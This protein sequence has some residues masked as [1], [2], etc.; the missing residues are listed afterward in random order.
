M[1]SSC[2]QSSL[3]SEQLAVDASL[4]TFEVPAT[5]TGEHTRTPEP[6]TVTKID[7]SEL[8]LGTLV[9]IEDPKATP[10]PATPARNPAR[11]VPFGGTDPATMDISYPTTPGATIVVPPPVPRR[12]AARSTPRPGSMLITPDIFKPPPPR[13]ERR[14]IGKVGGEENEKKEGAKKEDIADEKKEAKV[15]AE[16]VEKPTTVAEGIGQAIG[17]V[18][19]TTEETKE[20]PKVK[21]GASATDLAAQESLAVPE[22]AADTTT[23]NTPTNSSSPLPECV[24]VPVTEAPPMTTATETTPLD[25][26]SILSAS[27]ASVYTKD[28][29]PSIPTTATTEDDLAEDEGWVGNA[30]WEDRAWNRLVRIC[31]EMFWVCVG[32]GIVG[33][34]GL[35]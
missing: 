29:L 14:A 1:R 18:P 24:L 7:A 15:E 20:E 8:V 2:I 35:D 5:E 33:G 30:R 11:A 32:S 27:S 9:P 34:A 26:A 3:Q 28:I 19:I 6:K 10:A 13:S 25:Q 17:F 31:E 16:L 12:V 4:E 22:V 21:M 23:P